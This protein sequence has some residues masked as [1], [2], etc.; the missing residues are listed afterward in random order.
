MYCYVCTCVFV[1]GVL[2]CIV[3]MYVCMCLLMVNCGILYVCTYVFVD[4]YCGVLN[5]CMCV[6][7]C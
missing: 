2:W 1:D 6:C 7:V 5:V 3:C 4:G